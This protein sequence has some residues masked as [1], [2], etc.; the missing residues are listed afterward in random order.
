MLSSPVR[1]LVLAVFLAATL[2]VALASAQAERFAA[3]FID[4][5]DSTLTGEQPPDLALDAIRGVPDEVLPAFDQWFGENAH[6]MPPIYLFTYADRIYPVDQVQAARWFFA[7][8]TR[9]LYDAL[10]CRDTSVFERVAEVDSVL[11][12]I[13]AFVQDNPAEGAAAG[14]WALKWDSTHDVIE[15]PDALLRFC[16]TG[17][18]GR[19]LAIQQGKVEGV[20]RE[21]DLAKHPGIHIPLPDVDSAQGWV[22]PK[23]AY[24]KA[25]GDSF[26][27]TQRV[28]DQLVSRR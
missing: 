7:G 16:L 10:R 5:I 17:I 12:T 28:I 21:A 19:R 8:R 18:R 25:R 6:R 14:K 23:S 24:P 3:P 27:I 20:T 26:M 9:L 22:Q 13:V 11:A 4:A 15:R 1:I 2:P